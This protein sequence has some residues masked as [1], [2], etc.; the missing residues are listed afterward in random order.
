M[1]D[2][3]RAGMLG[4]PQGSMLGLGLLLGLAAGST[5]LAYRLLSM[6]YRMKS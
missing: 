1:V 6:G 3:L 2:G 4:L 5:L